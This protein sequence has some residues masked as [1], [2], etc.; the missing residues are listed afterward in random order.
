MWWA[1]GEPGHTPRLLVSGL[2]ADDQCGPDEVAV[3]VGGPGAY[4]IADDGQTAIASAPSAEES[5]RAVRAER[6][7]RLAASDRYMLS[8]FPIEDEAREFWAN[9]RNELRALP[10]AQPEATLD[11]VTW[12]SRPGDA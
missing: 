2:S 6:D 5:M 1:V 3:E 7:A 11:T 9:Y 4:V 12:P 8:D 10:E